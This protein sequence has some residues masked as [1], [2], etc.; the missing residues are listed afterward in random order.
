MSHSCMHLRDPDL[1]SH[2]ELMALAISL[3]KAVVAPKQH[4]TRCRSANLRRVV[5]EAE[6]P[7]GIQEPHQNVERF[8][9]CEARSLQGKRAMQ[10]GQSMYYIE[11]RP[12]DNVQA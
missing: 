3:R 1:I 4:G 9:S 2:K 10:F 7:A 6:D 12:G 5:Q 8:G 11:Y